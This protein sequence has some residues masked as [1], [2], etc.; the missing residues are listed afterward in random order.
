VTIR[1]GFGLITCQRTPQEA[2]SDVELYADALASAEEAERLGFDSVWVSEHHFVDDG[3]LPSLLPMCAAI[4]ARTRGIEV[5]TALL[6][7][8]LYEPLRLAEDAAVVDLLADG[9]LVLG[10]GLGWR[11]EEFEVLGVPIRDRVRRLEWAIEACKEAWRGAPVGDGR[12]VVTPLPARPGG[13]PIWIGGL[14]EP[15]AR[16]AG[17]IADGFMATEVTAASLAEQ[18]GW[19]R[20]EAE[21]AGRDPA[22]LT[23][24][25]HLPTYVHDGDADAGWTE[26]LPAHRYVGWKY[27]DMEGARSRPAGSPAPPPSSREEEQSLR[28]QIVFGA[29]EEVAAQIRALAEAAGGD[30]HF[31]ARLYWP[32]FTPERQRALLRRFA[33]RVMPLLDGG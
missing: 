6:L 23:T 22:S 14:S 3:Y 19:V 30:L 10:L 26:V 7:A 16:R 27:E 24:S 21:R 32:G 18:V 33:S 20:D 2:R 29:A 5:G 25:V 1:C 12:A 9:R 17:R 15:A 31:I 8:P 11:E 13:P 28:S 4:A